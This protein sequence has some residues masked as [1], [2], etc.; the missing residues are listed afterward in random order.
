MK[1]LTIIQARSSSSRLPRKSLMPIAGIPLAHLCAIRAKNNFSRLIVATSNESSDDDLAEM[2][3]AAG[4]EVFRGSLTNVLSRFI[5]IVDSHVLADEDT[6]IRLTGDNPIVDGEF[7]EILKKA[8]EKLGLDY[9]SGHPVDMSN[10]NWPYGLSAEFIKVGLLRDGYLRDKS[11]S[12]LEHVTA[13]ARVHAKNKAYGDQ[14]TNLTFKKKYFLTV[15]T[16]E[17]YKRVSEV[18]ERHPAN[19]CFSSILDNLEN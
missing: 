8:W 16:A 17:D 14:V 2:L 5:D 18:F 9:L 4:V 1:Y 3:L 13:Y 12:N 15:D 6:I 19:A 10:S 11:D 7:L